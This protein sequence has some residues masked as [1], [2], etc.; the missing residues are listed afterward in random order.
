MGNL[1]G[2]EAVTTAAKAAGGMDAYLST[3]KAAAAAGGK[4]SGRI[5]GAVISAGIATAYFVARKVWIRHV[6][7]RAQLEADAVLASQFLTEVFEGAEND[8]DDLDQGD[9][10]G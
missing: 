9:R 4:R 5:Q 2:Y 3:I 7:A 6:A 8:S 10:Q 1:G